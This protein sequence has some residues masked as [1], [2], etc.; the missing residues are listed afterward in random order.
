[1]SIGL[2][3][4]TKNKD[5]LVELILQLQETISEM[6]ISKD[7]PLNTDL[8][9]TAL[10][11]KNKALKIELSE[12]IKQATE[13]ATR[14]R[15]AWDANELLKNELVEARERTSKSKRGRYGRKREENAS[16]D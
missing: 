2:E 16:K 10:I 11:D 6:E 1:M 13:W 5:E 14:C 3:L 8:I 12:T 7:S 9:Y 15:K 4:R